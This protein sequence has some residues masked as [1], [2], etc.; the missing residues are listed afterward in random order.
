[1]TDQET[2]GARL[3]TENGHLKRAAKNRYMRQRRLE[4]AIRKH[5][6]KDCTCKNAGVCLA[7]LYRLI[8]LNPRPTY[9]MRH[10]KSK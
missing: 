5:V 3:A 4:E 8:P 1:M 6:E 9:G 10:V 7:N 2:L